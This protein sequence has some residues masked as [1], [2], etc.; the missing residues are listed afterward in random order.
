MNM[1]NALALFGF[2][3]LSEAAGIVGSFFTTPMIQSGWYAALRKPELAPPD[4]VFG[5]VWTILFALMGIAAFLVWR[6]GLSRKEVKRALSIFIAQLAL[7]TLWSFIFFGLQSP[8]GAFLEIILLWLTILATLI[9]FSRISRAAG[10]LLI[11]YLL[12]VSFAV[13]LN[14][15][16]W[17]L[18]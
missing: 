6:R 5:P 16:I 15:S 2:V 1:R 17:V 11:P 4:W 3:I 12:W 7:N 8:G 9:V 18:N 13:Y 10:W 14:Y